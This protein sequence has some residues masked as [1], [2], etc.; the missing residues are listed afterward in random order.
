MASYK[1]FIAGATEETNNASFMYSSY[2]LAE[3]REK[4]DEPCEGEST[5]TGYAHFDANSSL[6]ALK[7]SHSFST[8]F[9]RT[10]S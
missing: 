9:D 5:K 6:S 1:A 10:C 2:D 8:K 4:V 3:E 7:T